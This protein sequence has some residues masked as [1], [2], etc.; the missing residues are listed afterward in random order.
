MKDKLTNY[1]ALITLVMTAV[2]TYVDGLCDTCEINYFTLV[3]GVVVAVIAYLTGKGSDGK[4]LK[5]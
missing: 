5:Q 3:G 2:Q 4:A 1:L